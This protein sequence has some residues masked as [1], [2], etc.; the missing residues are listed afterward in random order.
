MESSIRSEA[1]TH[2]RRR[3]IARRAYIALGAVAF[4]AL[5]GFFLIR[6]FTHGRVSTDDAY[7]DAD[8]VP[9]SARVGGVIKALHVDD[10]QAV[11]AGAAILEIDPADAEARAAA[12]EADL[13][14]A[15]AQ[16]DAADA[17]VPVVRASSTG[18]QSSARA[19]LA[20]SGAAASSA[21]AEIEA[22]R[23][24]VARA[25]AD[26]RAASTALTR[27]RSLH[28]QGAATEQE[29]DAAQAAGD[30][31]A[32]Q[33]GA[34]RA[35]LASAQGAA[36]QAR[37]R[38]AEAAGRVEQTGAADRQVA[39][40]EAQARVAHGRVATAEAAL[41]RAR[42]DLSYTRVTAPGDGVAARLAVQVGQYVAP[43]QLLV[44]LVP[45]RT[46]VVAN[47]KESDVGRIR[48]GQ[49]ADIEVDAFPGQTFRGVVASV[50]PA[51][52]S[53]FS[54]LPASNATGNFVK[55]VQRVPVTLSWSGV[56]PDVAL[57]A[58]L[59]VEVTVH[60]E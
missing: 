26:A 49:P 53:R 11:A 5:A 47:F 8:V 29:L 34:A 12:A 50:S 6:H 38:V 58:G 1:D 41:A 43:G 48:R 45:R 28:A 30:A 4:A 40:A 51:T 22:A 16:A 10:D 44:E 46:Y 17:Q 37:S 19:Q 32:A 21:R 39:A 27:T 7:V 35:E 20:G 3:R 52:S 13:A 42:L 9:I 54:M 60:V 57:Q 2:S 24:T 36:Q 33:V 14:A 31:A 59:S 23:A 15:R 55:V 56:P 18:T 25:E